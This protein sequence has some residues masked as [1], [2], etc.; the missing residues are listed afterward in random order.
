MIERPMTSKSSSISNLKY[1]K[2]GHDKDS[3]PK[4]PP[5]RGI[6]PTTNINNF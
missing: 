5:Y 6:R 2:R 3:L 4:D 1:D